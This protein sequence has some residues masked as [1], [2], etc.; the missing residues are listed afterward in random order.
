VV[1]LFSLDWYFNQFLIVVARKMGYSFA[2]SM[3]PLELMCLIKK[4]EKI[5]SLLNE[6]FEE[7][8]EWYNYHLNIEQKNKECD[9]EQLLK[10][11]NTFTQTRKKIFKETERFLNDKEIEEMLN[12][13]FSEED[14]NAIV[15]GLEE[16]N[17]A[18]DKKNSE[19]ENK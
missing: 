4:D 13:P 5:Y 3:S 7:Y 19:K 9:F 14:C 15:K 16:I 12:T 11:S 10:L 6:F 2:E 18:I 1:M 17:R 8:K